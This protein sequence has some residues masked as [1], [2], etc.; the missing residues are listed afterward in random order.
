M[1]ARRVVSTAA[2]AVVLSGCV[3][4][5]IPVDMG[6]PVDMT[7]E[8][9]TGVWVSSDNEQSEQVR[10]WFGSEGEFLTCNFPAPYVWSQSEL[11]G[12]GAISIDGYFE[13]D[14]GRIYAGTDGSGLAGAH[15]ILFQGKSMAARCCEFSR[16]GIRIPLM[17]LTL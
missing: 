17:S 9:L 10:I 4:L 7:S 5:N 3:P 8:D 14:R 11:H 6:D 2:L 13:L 1:L 16:E 15:V 12:D